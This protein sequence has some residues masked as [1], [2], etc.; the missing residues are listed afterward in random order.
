MKRSEMVLNI[1]ST[2][3]LSGK[4]GQYLDF[5]TAKEYAENILTEIEKHMLPP[6]VKLGKLQVED[7]AWEPEDK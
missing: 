5:A 6:R 2:L 3:I 4:P 1:A 7:N